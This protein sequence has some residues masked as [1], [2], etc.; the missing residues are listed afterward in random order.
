MT[1]TAHKV[2]LQGLLLALTLS[3]CVA[4][5]DYRIPE[6]AVALTPGA[7]RDFVGAG[8]AAYSRAPLPD[9]WWRLYND[10]RLDAFVLE[11]LQANTDLRAADANLRRASAVVQEAEAARSIQTGI[12]ANA[13]AARVGGYT[14]PLPG[15]AYSYVL[16]M[17][18]SYP[19]D[20]AGGIRRGIEAAN[21]NA[22]AAQAARDQVRVV[23]A[24]AVTRSYANACSANRTLAAT[25]HVL[26]VQRE[27]LDVTR[28][29]ASAGRGTAFD[30]S[31]ARA[32]ANQSEAA[33][34]DI[35]AGREAALFELA[36]LMGRVPADY[37]KELDDC[38]HPPEL[39]HAMPI[40]DGWQLI[41]RRPDV[42]EAERH[43][44]AQTATIGVET[45]QL[46]PQ[47]SLGGAAGF[48]GPFNAI[49]GAS[50]GGTI[51]PLLSWNMPNRTVAHARIAEAG[52]GADAALANFDGVVLQALKQTE[53]SLSAY[54]QEIN[55]ERSLTRARDDA[56]QASDQANRLFRFGRTSFIDVL[57]AESALAN[58]ESE[59]AG[60]RAR[61]IDRQIGLF[62]ALGGGWKPVSDGS[63]ETGVTQNQHA[64]E[65]PTVRASVQY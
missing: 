39:E 26:A 19:L 41:Q 59:L 49:S 27:T 5:P 58:V 60:S 8:S 40:G 18:V 34:P 28:R 47:V 50:F 1:G 31:R 30:V 15:A 22:A 20:L 65:G 3:G 2:S 56:A 53:S 21:A 63:A 48:A 7:T 24:A 25:Q 4:G 35:V 51:G 14:L 29:L 64:R 11:A 45:A 10:R 36:A 13:T 16:G 17:S 42:R 33:I 12:S 43:L 37:P 54:S 44:A 6:H 62:L 52:A 9:Q 46:Y 38:I 23:V 55:R 32:A 57:T 61:L